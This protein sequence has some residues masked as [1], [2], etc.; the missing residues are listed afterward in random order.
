MEVSPKPKT[1]L[2]SRIGKVAAAVGLALVIGGFAIGSAHADNRR[3]ERHAYKNHYNY[4]YNR[5]YRGR[6]YYA[7]GQPDYYY[8]RPQPN[9]YNAPDP[10]YYGSDRRYDGRRRGLNLFFGL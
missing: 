5:G 9:Y 10:Y 1:Q 2:R 4:N 7:Y 3:R 6:G 8:Y